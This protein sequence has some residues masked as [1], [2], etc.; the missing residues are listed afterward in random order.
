VPNGRS[1]KFHIRSD[2]QP[3]FVD[4]EHQ[5]SSRTN[6]HRIGDKGD[7]RYTWGWPD[8]DCCS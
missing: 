6:L 7:G 3:G 1:R 8:K 5:S 4:Y 2:I